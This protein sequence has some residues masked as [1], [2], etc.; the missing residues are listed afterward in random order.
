MKKLTV[1][2]IVAFAVLLA[3]PVFAAD[4]IVNGVDLWMTRGDGTSFADFTKQPIPAG[5]FCHKSR[6]FQGRIVM[7]GLPLATG[8][9][10][11]LKN[12]DTI[13]QRLD[14]A[15]FNEQGVATTR[16]QVRAMQFE[17]V[18][19]IK[20]ACGLY[21]AYVTLD[22]EQPITTMRIVREH[23]KGGRFYAPISVNIKIS[24]KPVGR[25]TTETFELRKSLR[26]PPARDQQWSFSA[27]NVARYEGFVKVDTDS[28]GVPD[29]FLPGTSNF[30]AGWPAVPHRFEPQ[31]KAALCAIDCHCDDEGIHCP[32]VVTSTY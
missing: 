8:E 5:F 9:P 2:T 32:A 7:R 19:P 24:F 12:T 27:G 23:E 6:P 31:Q 17:A 1:F 11:A 18:A 3:A 28:D 16:I 14:D 25:V 20:T 4:R 21:K 30:A 10:G 29:T 22:G 13:V 15:V 26:F